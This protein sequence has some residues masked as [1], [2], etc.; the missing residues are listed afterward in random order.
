MNNWSPKGRKYW[1]NKRKDRSDSTEQEESDSFST[2]R[3]PMPWEPQDNTEDNSYYWSGEDS[4][5]IDLSGETVLPTIEIIA[6]RPQTEKS[7]FLTDQI[8]GKSPDDFNPKNFV[9]RIVMGMLGRQNNSSIPKVIGNN[10]ISGNSI[11]SQAWDGSEG[12]RVLG[13]G[14]EYVP[15]DAPIYQNKFLPSGFI[16]PVPDSFQLYGS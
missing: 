2:E 1:G 7:K 5:E 13:E 6:E 16:Y 8:Q 14:S 12:S 15:S 10:V 11:T 9:N 4:D 3:L